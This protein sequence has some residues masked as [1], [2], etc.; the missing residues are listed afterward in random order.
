M[1]FLLSSLSADCALASSVRGG[2]RLSCFVRD[3]SPSV[4]CFFFLFASFQLGF[5]S[6]ACL[7]DFFC[8]AAAVFRFLA[9]SFPPPTISLRVVGGALVASEPSVGGSLTTRPTPPP[10]ARA[11]RS[12]TARDGRERE[13]LREKGR[14]VIHIGAAGS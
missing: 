2:E 13:G 9:S 8:A 10:L 5:G 1:I 14:I 12:L 11:K 3:H 6:F 7:S 4:L